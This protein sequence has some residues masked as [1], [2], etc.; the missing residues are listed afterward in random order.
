[1]A[2]LA[3]AAGSAARLCRHGTRGTWGGA[4]MRAAALAA[5][6]LLLRPHGDTFTALD[7]SGYRLMAYAFAEGRG[8]NETDRMVLELPDEVRQDCTLLPRT[9]ERNTRDRSFRLRSDATGATEPFFYPT[10]P[11]A[12]AA[13]QRIW[14]LGGLDL[15]VPLVGLA[16][17][18]TLLAAGRRLGG[19]A[20][21]A[22]AAALFLAT[23]LPAMLLRGFYAEVCG[24]AFVALA[25]L[26]WLTLPNG[27]PVS[28]AA[29]AALGLAPAIHP[30]LIVVSL[31]LLAALV[32]VDGGSARR[33]L[34][35][36]LLFGVGLALLAWITARVCAPYGSL[37]WSNL[38]YNFK[39]SQS[40][41]V[42]YVF[43]LVFGA[44]LAGL[45]AWRL[46]G[47]ETFRRG[48]ERLHPR[49]SAWLLVA[50]VPLAL[51]L[52]VWAEA[53]RVE[54][55]L[56]DL[57]SAVGWPAAWLALACAAAVVHP[58]GG[59]RAR[60][61]AGVA[62]AVLPVFA[63]LKG[64]E[65]MGMW[66]Q[67]RIAPF[68]LLLLPALLVPAARRLGGWRLR[69]PG[70]AVLAGGL[71]LALGGANLV[72][73][74]APYGVRQE[75]G[76]TERVERLKARIGSRLAFF[77]YLPDSFPFA[78]DNRT[79][80]A[81][82]SSVAKARKWDMLVAWLRERAAAEEVWVVSSYSAPGLEEGL[83]LVPLFTES[84]PVARIRSRQALPAVRQDGERV[85]RFLRAEPVGAEPLALDK[86]LDGG[87]L[88]LRGAWGPVR[89]MVLPD[90]TRSQGQWSREGCG[91]VGPVPPRG[92]V[93]MTLVASSGRPEQSQRL[94]VVPPW[95][96][97]G[98]IW[99][100]VP[101]V[102]TEL[103]AAF[104]PPPAA[105]QNRTGIYRFHA[106]EP[107]DP[108]GNGPGDYPADLG[109]LIQRVRLAEAE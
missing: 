5:A 83:R 4:W 22:L 106:A 73:W 99:L 32:C 61:L 28:L 18:W 76:A 67:R 91:V 49:A 33:V 2:I 86:Q 48:L 59:G 62:W 34:A 16:L 98:A 52:G 68:V 60:F 65:Q 54:K 50:G 88:A 29:Y 17:A 94:R 63:Y 3:F 74:P 21:L 51:A 71:A 85:L 107:Y 6:I 57:W 37:R 19:G 97:A 9:A 109:A 44:A 70:A 35:G 47:A 87:P 1:M 89:P 72:R 31:P 66:S 96:E 92:R 41:Q 77:D 7:H 95:G 82:W 84:I 13:L 39:G 81:G 45:L 69:R 10:L 108:S 38:A 12:A 26:H 27:R 30:V 11:L 42:A 103:A 36:L 93:R 43:M 55:E 78:V 104:E 53:P 20:G 8:P 80:V 58:A 105:A 25:A 75:A 100:D 15:F 101:S 102:A 79:R 14:P 56:A 90:G 24:G 64:A 46:R 23:P 40:H